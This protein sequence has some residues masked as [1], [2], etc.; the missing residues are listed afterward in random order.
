VTSVPPGSYSDIA[1]GN[2]FSC[3]IRSGQLVCWGNL[4]KT[5]SLDAGSYYAVTAGKKHVCAL[6]PGGLVSCFDQYGSVSSPGTLFTSIASS[7]GFTCGVTLT[8]AIHCWGTAAPTPPSI[9]AKQVT[10]G[11]AHACAIKSDGHVAC[12]GDNSH[13]QSSPPNAVFKDISAFSYRTCGIREDGH[14]LCWGYGDASTGEN[15]PPLW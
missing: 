2:G 14:A 7:D 8:N 9:T 13:G 15:I 10:C 3:A 11:S 6:G 5:F 4:D 1:S 12:W